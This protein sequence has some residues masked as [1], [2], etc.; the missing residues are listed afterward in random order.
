M[1]QLADILSLSVAE[2]IAMAEAIWDSIKKEEVS[3]SDSQM[4]ELDYRMALHDRGEISYVSWDDLKQ[5]L[6]NRKS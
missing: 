3:L 5:E 1:V 2:R 4:E 6:R